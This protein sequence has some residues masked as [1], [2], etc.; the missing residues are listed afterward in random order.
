MKK[1]IV[2]I[3]SISA[4][5][6]HAQVV[7][8]ISFEVLDHN[9]GVINEADGPVTYEFRFT[10]N[11]NEPIKIDDVKASC[12]CTTPAW[13][14]EPVLPG[15]WGFVQAQYN[16]E[17]RAGRFNKSLTINT[18]LGSVFKAYI[19]GE[20]TPQKS[21]PHRM[22][23]AEFGAL[24]MKY[25]SLNMGKL[26]INK[27]PVTKKFDVYNQSDEPVSLSKNIESPSH[28]TVAFDQYIIAPKSAATMSVTYDAALKNDLGFMNDSFEFS[29]DEQEN[30]RK[31]MTVYA[32]LGEF[33]PKKEKENLAGTPN[34]KIASATHDFG[35]ITQE[36]VAIAEIN[37]ANTGGRALEIKKLAPN[38]PCLIAKVTSD[39][40][41]AGG[42][43]TVRILFDPDGRKGNQ[44]KSLTVYSNDPR[45]PAQRIT[46]KAYIK[47]N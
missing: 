31:Q 21:E 4:T 33:F 23:P 20:V 3:L 32:T 18:S 22:Y 19:R 42:S 45:A 41:E 35:N 11:S 26:Y 30:A 15:Q 39:R 25:G 2:F 24:R 28:I 17:N 27:K 36:E 47:E 10:N 29:T 6:L 8:P 38:C 12:G 46:L 9:F 16:P 37:L 7:A 34:L 43:A 14:R 44:Q 40:I 1:L 5:G 13:T